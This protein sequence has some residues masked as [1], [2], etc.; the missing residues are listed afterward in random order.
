MPNRA[1]RDAAYFQKEIQVLEELRLSIQSFAFNA[2]EPA[3]RP[4]VLALAVH[5]HDHAVATGNKHLKAEYARLSIRCWQVAR[6][7]P[8]VSRVSATES[9]A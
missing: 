9:V 1:D 2:T 3:S 5:L 7:M 6:R 8:R 4:E